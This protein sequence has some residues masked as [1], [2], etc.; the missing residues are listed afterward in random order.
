MADH[1]QSALLLHGLCETDRR[2]ILERLRAD[3]QRILG[4]H[5]AELNS[6]GIPADA[7]LIDAVKS[8]RRRVAGDPLHKATSAQMRALLVNE[9]VWLVRQVLALDNWSWRGDFIAALAPMQQERL[10]AARPAPLSAKPAQCLREQLT[11][12]LAQL[13]SDRMAYLPAPR[14]LR[15]LLQQAV[16]RWI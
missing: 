5:L 3:D 12:R 6:L 8:S 4:D 15:A 14:G 13:D 10:A 1:R 11:Q 7:G 9:P 16:R 2:Y